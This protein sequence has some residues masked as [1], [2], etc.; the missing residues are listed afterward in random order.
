MTQRDGRKAPIISTNINLKKFLVHFRRN[1]SYKGEFGF[2][3]MKDEYIYPITQVNGAPKELSL[4]ISKLKTEYKTKDVTDPK[5]I[6]TK[7]YYCSFLNL[8]L[9]QEATFDIEVKELETLLA[10]ATEIVFESSNPDLTITPTTIPLNILI[11]GG[12]KNKV[13]VNNTDPAKVVSKNYYQASNQVVVKCNKA[14]IKNEQIKVFAKL[15]DTTTGLEEKKEVGKMMVMKNSEQALFTINVYV[16]K[17]FLS[18]NPL[19]GESIIDTEFAKIGGLL[20]LEKYIN[21]NSLN[22]GLI[23]SKVD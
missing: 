1:V 15:K 16:I 11:A 23:K 21:E 13:L 10:D 22:Q 6:H 3:W 8:M 14:F 12:K 17:A 9:N 19:F 5:T 2:D 4:D 18:D 20:G 7:D